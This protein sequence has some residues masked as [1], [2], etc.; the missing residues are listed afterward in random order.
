MLRP[1]GAFFLLKLKV[2]KIPIYKI[3]PNSGQSELLFFPCDSRVHSEG[4]FRR[5]G[6]HLAGKHAH[7]MI[8]YRRDRENFSLWPDFGPILYG[9]FEF[10]LKK[11]TY[12]SQ[13]IFFFI[14]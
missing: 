8:C 1:I 4:I 2:T 13:N 14:M 6:V 10:E 9:H 3:G 11:G 12:R 5:P 7:C